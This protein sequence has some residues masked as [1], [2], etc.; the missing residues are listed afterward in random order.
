VS[1]YALVPQAANVIAT[2]QS[3][4]IQIGE[5]LLECLD[6]QFTIANGWGMGRTSFIASFSSVASEMPWLGKARRRHCAV[7]NHIVCFSEPVFSVAT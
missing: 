6:R 1:R 4:Q 5:N 3:P 2:Q 7:N